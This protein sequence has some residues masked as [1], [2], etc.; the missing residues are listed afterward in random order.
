MGSTSTP[1][2]NSAA[3]LLFT[4]LHCS[5][6]ASTDE[7]DGDLQLLLQELRQSIS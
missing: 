3:P 4:D 7:R 5:C 2:P 1:T 6:V